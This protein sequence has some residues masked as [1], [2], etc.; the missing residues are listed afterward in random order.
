MLLLAYL[1]MTSRFMTG[2]SYL[3]SKQKTIGKVSQHKTFSS[4]NEI[5]KQCIEIARNSC[6]ILN[7]QGIK[8]THYWGL[9]KLKF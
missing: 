3:Y 9:L 6:L 7:W 8:G 5:C 4:I 1:L 2:G